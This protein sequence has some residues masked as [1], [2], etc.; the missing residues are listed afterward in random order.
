MAAPAQPGVLV[1]YDNH[2]GGE[3]ADEN[4]DFF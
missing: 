1:R 2:A 4:S 3:V